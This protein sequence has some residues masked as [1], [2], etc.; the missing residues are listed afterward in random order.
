MKISPKEAAEAAAAYAR[1]IVGDD[2]LRNL[3]VEEVEPSEGEDWLITLGWVEKGSKTVG[4]AGF[5]FASTPSRIEALPRVY[6]V[7]QVDGQSGEVLSMK[8]R[9]D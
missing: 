4:G 3:R 7:F 5:P 1:E 2:E 6:K 8:M 9:D